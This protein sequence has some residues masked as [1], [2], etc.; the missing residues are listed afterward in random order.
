[1]L[2]YLSRCPQ[3][4]VSGTAGIG[5]KRPVCFREANGVSGRSFRQAGRGG[6]AVLWWNAERLLSGQET[7]LADD[8]SCGADGDLPPSSAL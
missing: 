4:G 5:G 2:P 3:L 8:R 7:H 6:I 1:M